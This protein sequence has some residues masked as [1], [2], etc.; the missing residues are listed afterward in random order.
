[1]AYGLAGAHREELKDK[2]RAELRS[3]RLNRSGINKIVRSRSATPWSIKR[4]KVMSRTAIVA[5]ILLVALGGRQP[6]FAQA[7]ISE[8]GAYAFYHP[9][10]DLLNTGLPALFG[11]ANSSASERD[12]W[13][14]GHAPTPQSSLRRRRHFSAADTDLT[15]HRQACPERSTAYGTHGAYAVELTDTSHWE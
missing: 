8:P 14:D 9:D 4:S 1:M 12:S 5:T 3:Y 15:C 10:A 7:A 13:I 2:Q 11:S 6:V